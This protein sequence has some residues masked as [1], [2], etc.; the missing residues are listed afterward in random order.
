MSPDA[1]YFFENAETGETRDI[2]GK[3]VI[4]DGFTFALPARNGV[5]WFY[6][7]GEGVGVSSEHGSQPPPP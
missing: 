4:R 2:P 1:R 6:R 7:H 3:D 5:I